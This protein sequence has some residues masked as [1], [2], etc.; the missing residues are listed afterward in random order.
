MHTEHNVWLNMLDIVYHEAMQREAVQQFLSVLA[1]PQSESKLVINRN[2]HHR[3][4]SN[5]ENT[6][7]PIIQSE[8]S[9]EKP[10]S[11]KNSVNSSGTGSH[12]AIY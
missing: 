8:Q 10:A 9:L 11:V 5:Y 12:H 7:D 4:T 6:Q 3:A 2:V 1:G